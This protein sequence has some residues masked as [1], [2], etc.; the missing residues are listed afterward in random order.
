MFHQAQFSAYEVGLAS[1]HREL[2]AV[3]SAL[4]SYPQAFSQG[5]S[6]YWLTDSENVVAFLT[7]GSAKR[8]I[9]S[10]VVEIYRLAR[11]L[12]L[13]IMPLHLT[14]ADYRMQIADYGSRY[15]DPDDWTCDSRSFEDLTSHWLITIDLFAHYSNCLL[16]TSP[17]PRDRQKSRMPSSA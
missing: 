7:K 14:R 9:Q 11:A 16:Y 13:D 3:K 1:G 10:V 15:Y 5:T 4:Q 12:L 6:V 8:H 2:L 17:S